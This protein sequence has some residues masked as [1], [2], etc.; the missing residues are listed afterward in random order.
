MPCA[1]VSRFQVNHIAVPRRP[2]PPR[3]KGTSRQG[4]VEYLGSGRF[5]QGIYPRGGGGSPRDR[6]ERLEVFGGSPTLPPTAEAPRSGDGGSAR[7][8]CAGEWGSR[9]RSRRRQG[10]R[11]AP[12][13]S[14]ARTSATD[15]AID[16]RAEVMEWRGRRLTARREVNPSAR[17]RRRDRLDPTPLARRQ[18][19]RCAA[20]QPAKTLLVGWGGEAAAQQPVEPGAVR[21]GV[22]G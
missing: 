16:G 19:C 10:S 22:Y 12:T 18:G 9:S 14:G 7:D 6:I 4:R 5:T 1:G 21:Q 17:S 13:A 20:F 2:R 15:L 3:Q 11:H 8:R